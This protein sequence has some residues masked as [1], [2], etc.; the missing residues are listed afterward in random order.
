[1]RVFS[2]QPREDNPSWVEGWCPECAQ[3]FSGTT[4]ST[5][6]CSECGAILHVTSKGKVIVT[7]KEGA[8]HDP[9]E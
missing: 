4:N 6:T 7:G 3:A 1:M 8:S 9:Q 2:R 5:L